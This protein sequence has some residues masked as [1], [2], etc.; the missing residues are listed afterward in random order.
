M[1][2]KGI[3][4]NLSRD[5][6]APSS[7]RRTDFAIMHRHRPQRLTHPHLFVSAAILSLLLL[8]SGA[9]QAQAQQ[10]FAISLN[11][12]Q[13]TGL[14]AYQRDV[15]YTSPTSEPDPALAGQALLEPFLADESNDW[16]TQLAV[17]LHVNALFLDL[18]A[19][20]HTR[21]QYTLHHRSD[22]RISRTRQRPS[23]SYD[24]AGITYTAMEESTIPAIERNRGSLLFANLQAGWRYRALDLDPFFVYIPVAFGMSLAHILEPARPYKV[25]AKL[26]SGSTL[27]YHFA[28]NFALSAGVQLS[29]IVT[30]QYKDREDAYRRAELRGASTFQAMT[31]S[32]VQATLDLGLVFIVR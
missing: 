5:T 10:N 23:G 31:S 4:S 6:I 28:E 32:M 11:L 30:P 14:T 17:R 1:Q 16:G 29:W 24:D 18:N 22:D 2:E 8:L 7:P 3:L 19:Q 26:S 12:G 13:S 27:Q 9:N 20:W 15:V 25:G 21:N